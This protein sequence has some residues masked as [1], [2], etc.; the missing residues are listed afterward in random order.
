MEVCFYAQRSIKENYMGGGNLSLF[1]GTALRKYK[2][3]ARNMDFLI[4]V[5]AF[6][7]VVMPL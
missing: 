3:P 2:N 6:L 5:P 7:H 1:F 4:A